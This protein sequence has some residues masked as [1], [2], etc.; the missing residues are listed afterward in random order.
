MDGGLA[1]AEWKNAV[2][3]GGGGGG[4][5]EKIWFH[6]DLNSPSL[7]WESGVLTIRPPS[8]LRNRPQF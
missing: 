1:V 7:V 5:E 3:G 8:Y 6:W 2:G 4:G